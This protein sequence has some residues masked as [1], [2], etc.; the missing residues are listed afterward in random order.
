[1]RT[2]K[3]IAPA[4]SATSPMRRF[5]NQRRRRGSKFLYGLPG[6]HRRKHRRPRWNRPVFPAFLA[7]L[8]PN[9]VF[10]SSQD[11]LFSRS[12]PSRA[13]RIPFDSSTAAERQA[14][15][16]AIPLGGELHAIS[17]SILSSD[18]L[19][20]KLLGVGKGCSGTSREFGNDPRNGD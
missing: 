7:R 12:S 4:R 5:R 16:A 17:K 11:K 2:M 14:V 8:L 10:S 3:R 1:M 9:F 15:S 20:L 6:S 19:F 18:D 13:A